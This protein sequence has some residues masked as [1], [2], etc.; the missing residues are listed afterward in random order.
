MK[1]GTKWLIGILLVVVVA[2]GAVYISDPEMFQGKLQLRTPQVA[3]MEKPEV[4]PLCPAEYNVLYNHG[5]GE[6]A[7]Y[8]SFEDLFEAASAGFNC[9]IEMSAFP[10]DRAYTVVCHPSEVRTYDIGAE[11][12]IVCTKRGNGT[13][14][15]ITVRKNDKRNTEEALFV[16]FTKDVFRQDL[17]DNFRVDMVNFN[18]AYIQ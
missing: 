9:P 5:G 8:N 2:V 7:T 16:D 3:E 17:T 12:S 18:F 15:E 6:S 11:K 10:E 14:Q 4:K 13:I 1:K